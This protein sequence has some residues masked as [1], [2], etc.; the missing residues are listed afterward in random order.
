MLRSLS[1]KLSTMHHA[2]AAMKGQDQTVCKGARGRIHRSVLFSTVQG[3]ASG[4]GS[5]P[6][7]TRFDR[8]WNLSESA[9]VTLSFLT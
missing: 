2:R 9:N 8:R 4:P 3:V 6:I 7:G 5:A 1:I